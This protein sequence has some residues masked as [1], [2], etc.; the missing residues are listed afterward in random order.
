MQRDLEDKLVRHRSAV[1]E[2]LTRPGGVNPEDGTPVFPGGWRGDG[3]LEWKSEEIKAVLKYARPNLVLSCAVADPN[4]LSSC[5]VFSWPNREPTRSFIED[6]A[7]NVVSYVLC[8]NKIKKAQSYLDR[9]RSQLPGRGR[10]LLE[11]PA[12]SRGLHR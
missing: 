4:L 6:H 7:R 1:Y 10:P 3:F 2:R 8:P 9:Y 12:A 5:R 11:R